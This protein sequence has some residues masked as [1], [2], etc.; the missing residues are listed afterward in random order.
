MDHLRREEADLFDHE[1]RDRGAERTTQ[2]GAATDE[3]EG[4][5]RLPRVVEIVGERPELADE[6]DPEN[7]AEHVER[8]RDPYRTGLEQQPRDDEEQHE[9]R[10]A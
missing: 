7:Q 10:P 4:P 9:S 3:P 6:E 5:F 1:R 2:T 8:D